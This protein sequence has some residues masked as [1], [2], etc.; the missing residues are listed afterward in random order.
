MKQYDNYIINSAEIDTC[1]KICNALI[2]FNNA[3]ETFSHVYKPTSNQF[4]RE[5]VNLAGAFSNFENADYVSYFASFMKEK[6]LKYYSH[7]SH[8]YGIAFGLDP[9][10][11]L[12]SL[13]ECLNYYYAAFFGPLPMYEDNPIDPKKEYN[14]VSDIFYALFNEFHA[15]Y[16]NAPPPPTQTSSKGKSNFKSTFANLI[17]KRNQLPLHNKAQL[18]RFLCI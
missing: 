5:A 1:E 14:E 3:T 4:I 11:R 12:G 17:K 15:Q 9:R 10:F 13:E 8:I 7:I 2:Y 6:F 18:M 16:G